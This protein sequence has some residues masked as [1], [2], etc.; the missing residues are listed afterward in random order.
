MFFISYYSS[1]KTPIIQ[2]TIQRIKYKQCM[3]LGDIY[4]DN[5]FSIII[6]RLKKN[7]KG[8]YLANERPSFMHDDDIEESDFL[9]TI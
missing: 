1:I 6:R 8:W 5:H 7:K 4:D 3:Y 9:S 2:D